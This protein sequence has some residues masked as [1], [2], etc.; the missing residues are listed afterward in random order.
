MTFAQIGKLSLY[1]EEHGE[2]RPGR[3]PLVLLHGG[4]S[5]TVSYTHLTLPTN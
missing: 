5:T 2:D 3:V 1:Y 4:G